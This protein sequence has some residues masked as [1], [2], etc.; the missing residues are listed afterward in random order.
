MWTVAVHCQLLDQRKPPVSGSGFS[1]RGDLRGRGRQTS[2]AFVKLD[3]G[4]R[5]VNADGPSLPWMHLG[6]GRHFQ[7][8]NAA[9]L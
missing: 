8:E 3:L 2:L 7:K 4:A 5:D 6:L 1:H 9:I